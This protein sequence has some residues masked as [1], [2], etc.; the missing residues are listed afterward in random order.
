MKELIGEA[1]DLV[2]E[3]RIL[4]CRGIDQTGRGEAVPEDGL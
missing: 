1:N 2:T 3:L 4:R